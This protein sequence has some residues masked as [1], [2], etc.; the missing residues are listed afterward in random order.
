MFCSAMVTLTHRPWDLLLRTPVMPHWFV[1]IEITN[2]IANTYQERHEFAQQGCCSG[3]ADC[4]SVSGRGPSAAH[5]W[6]AVFGV[7]RNP[8]RIRLIG[9][10]ALLALLMILGLLGVLAPRPKGVK[11]FFGPA[12]TGVTLQFLGSATNY[13]RFDDDRRWKAFSV[14][15][16]T[17][18]LLV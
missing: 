3:R 14:S 10:G 17:S 16:W 6:A 15:N 4:A 12:P 9:I 13:L 1:G 11:P 5:H 7:M 2:H 18:K 8:S